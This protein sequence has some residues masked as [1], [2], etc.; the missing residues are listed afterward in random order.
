MASK[1]VHRLFH[2][3]YLLTIPPTIGTLEV[4]EKAIRSLTLTKH[5]RLFYRVDGH[6][7]F[8]INVYDN[9]SSKLRKKF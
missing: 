5:K 8:I 6:Y 3:I 9:R 1:F 7:I 4:P 2:T